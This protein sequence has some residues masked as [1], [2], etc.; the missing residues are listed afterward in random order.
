MILLDTHALVWF[1]TK[2]TSLST[3]ALAKIEKELQSSQLFIS[4]ISIW[5]ISQLVNKKR[6]S[7]SQSLQKTVTIINTMK[8]LNFVPVNNDIAYASQTLPGDFHR[9]PADQLIVAT[10]RSLGATL[11]TKDKKIRDYKHVKTI[12]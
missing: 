4:S 10:T 6:I 9:D 5:E 3:K 2:P 12:W 11:I 7:F 1:L 8:E